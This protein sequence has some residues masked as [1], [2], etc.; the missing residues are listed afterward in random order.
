[1]P[2]AGTRRPIITPFVPFSMT[3]QWRLPA[4][5]RSGPGNQEAPAGTWA[6]AAAAPKSG[7]SPLR[8]ASHSEAGREGRLETLNTRSR[9]R[10]R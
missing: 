9:S 3:A 7:H 2:P 6:G 4:A 10:R 1:M 5:G 8:R